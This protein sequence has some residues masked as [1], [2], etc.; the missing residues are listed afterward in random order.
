MAQQAISQLPSVPHGT[1]FV[2]TFM[3]TTHCDGDKG[4]GGS[5][6]ERDVS[7]SASQ[8]GIGARGDGASRLCLIVC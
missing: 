4:Q 5:V 7:G 1:S 3:P 6:L 2:S 8:A